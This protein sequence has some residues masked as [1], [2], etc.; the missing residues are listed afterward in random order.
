[1]SEKDDKFDLIKWEF[2]RTWS[3]CVE[4]TYLN[5]LPVKFPLPKIGYWEFRLIF[6]LKKIGKENYLT[7]IDEEQTALFKDPVRTAQ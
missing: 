7:F 6:I 3:L 5:T 4:T 1:M 2:E